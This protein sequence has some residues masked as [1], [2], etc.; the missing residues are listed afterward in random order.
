MSEQK[1]ERGCR[2]SKTK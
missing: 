1:Q 2:K